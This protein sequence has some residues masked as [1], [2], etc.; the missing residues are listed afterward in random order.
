MSGQPL[1]PDFSAFPSEFV[2]DIGRIKL[3]VFDF[4]GVFTD[5]RVYV[6]EDGLESVSCWRSDGLGLSKIR[7]LGIPI[8]VI[9]TEKNPVVSARCK[10]L[11]IDCIQNCDDKLAALRT[12]IQKY[13]CSLSE[14]L[15]TG[16]DINDQYCLEAV[17]LPFVV[18]D[19]HPDVIA[20]SRYITL[21]LGGRGAVREICDL[22]SFAH[23]NKS[24]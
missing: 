17:G 19:A 8:W 7:K 3:L 9:S 4:D 13:G 15:F 14:T 20:F 5:N 11:Q 10:K 1:Q 16:N 6:S 24:N 18:A 12:L 2:R 22:V 21:N 23:K